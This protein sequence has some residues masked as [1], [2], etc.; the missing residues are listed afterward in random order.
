VTFVWLL[1]GPAV[2]AVSI[3]SNIFVRTKMG[4]SKIGT[5]L[6]GKK[7]GW[8]RLTAEFTSS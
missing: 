7:K 5:N 4:E 3:E 8:K 1:N 2:N 6:F